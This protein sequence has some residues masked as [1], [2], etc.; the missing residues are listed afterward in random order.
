MTKS[1]VTKLSPQERERIEFGIHQ[2]NED[3]RDRFIDSSYAQVQSLVDIQQG[4]YEKLRDIAN[5][6]ITEVR[7]VA[8]PRNQGF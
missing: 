8:E 7:R 1:L 6:A 4:R 2:P 3:G 5:L